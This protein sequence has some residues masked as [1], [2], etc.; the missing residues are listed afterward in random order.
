MDL[1]QSSSTGS[2]AEFD[3]I[4]R[5]VTRTLDVPAAVFAVVDLE[6]QYFKSVHGLAIA[7]T[8]RNVGLF[9]Q[10]MLSE[11]PTVCENATADPRFRD[12]P[13]VTGHPGIRFFAGIPVR[14]PE[15]LTIGAL[16]AVDL[17][18]RTIS[19]DGLEALSDLGALLGRELVLRSLMRKDPLTGLRNSSDYGIELDREWRRARRGNH[20][21]SA[22][23]MDVDRLGEF[24]DTFGHAHGDRALRAIGDMLLRRFR[25]GSDLLI[26][27]GGDRILALLP[28][29][30]FTESRRMA[31]LT[32]ADVRRLELG[33]PNT[34]SSLTLSIGCA[35][36]CKDTG[37]DFGC[38]GLIAKATEALRTAKQ[39]GGDRIIQA[40]FA[41]KVTS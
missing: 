26:R 19:A 7:E 37:Y 22:L 40:R 8:P 17:R 41:V 9:G 32:R 13:L 30:D 29:T 23:I 21:L 6:R 5:L 28:D 34:S 27:I 25:R 24:N 18:P 20:P 3:R 35:T 4:V 31:E 11:T 12:H 16:C 10:A 2:D 14:S 15:A 1:L 39:Q 38:E 33:N 36:A